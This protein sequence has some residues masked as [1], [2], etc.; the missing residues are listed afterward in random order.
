VSSNRAG[1]YAKASSFLD[2]LTAPDRI[3]GGVALAP[4]VDWA[5]QA[6]GADLPGVHDAKPLVPRSPM[7]LQ[8]RDLRSRG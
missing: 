6:S 2:S 5:G 8:L 7:C 1:S 3:G 4:R